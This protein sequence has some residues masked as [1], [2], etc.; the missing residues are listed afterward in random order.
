MKKS[1]QDRIVITGL[2]LV[3]P[4]GIG[5]EEFWENALAGKHGLDYVQFNGLSRNETFTGGVIK[6]F[7]PKD[8]ITQRKSLKIMSRDM[9][10][11][12]ASAKL[13]L[14]DAQ[15]DVTAHDPAQFGVCIGAGMINSDLRELGYPIIE[16]AKDNQFQIKEFGAVSSN[17]MFPLWL[18]KQLPNM[19][20]SHISIIYNAQGPSNTLT[21]A[22]AAGLQAIGEATRIIERKDASWFI[23]GGADHRIHPLDFL[24][25]RMLGLLCE[26]NGRTIKDFC[27]YDKRRS[28]FI[29]GE[30]SAIMLIET[31]E[32][33]L[34]RGVDIYAE[35]IGY[36]ASAGVVFR[37]K[38]LEKRSYIESLAISRAI[39]DAGISA[40]DIDYIVG[41]GCSSVISDVVETMAYK[42]ALGDYAKSVPVSSPSSMLGYVGSA[43]GSVNL[44]CAL[45]AMRDSKIPP[46]MFLQEPDP[47]CD[48]DYVPNTYREHKVDIA[49]VNTFDFYG[50]GAAVLVKKFE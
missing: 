29:P 27:P 26:N 10:I 30:A 1:N 49:L 39:E 9:Q 44:V 18:L 33:A 15:Y 3:T 8:Y 11:A 43:T 42:K 6:N 16:S 21:T 20:A 34:D 46:T 41:H 35:I 28:G 2:G 5:K 48:L 17:T 36:G 38:D 12:V 19:L 24:K 22:S 31:L 14:E 13:A 47:L 40:Q 50:Q 4:L 45:M 37:D 32:S 7:R 25:Y 23:C